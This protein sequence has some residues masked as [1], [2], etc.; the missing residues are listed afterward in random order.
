VFIRCERES[1]KG[2][3]VGKSGD[4]IKKIRTAAAAELKKIFDWTI[5]LDIRVKTDKNWRHNDNIIK[6]FV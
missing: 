5:K 2:M 3:I 1:Q 4:M 6:K